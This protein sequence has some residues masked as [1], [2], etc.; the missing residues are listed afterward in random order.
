MWDKHSAWLTKGRGRRRRLFLTSPRLNS[1]S[2]CGS[3]GTSN[4]HPQSDWSSDYYV[5]WR[6]L[7]VTKL[8][9]RSR[10]VSWVSEADSLLF[11]F[12]VC[13]RLSEATVAPGRWRLQR[14]VSRQGLCGPEGGCVSSNLLRDCQPRSRSG[15]M[16]RSIPPVDKCIPRC[17]VQCSLKQREISHYGPTALIPCPA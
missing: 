9:F 1:K 4:L 13:L 15:W 6:Q 5:R 8:G 10:C 12:I 17:F 2:G 3:E 14:A 7:K 16:W 11:H